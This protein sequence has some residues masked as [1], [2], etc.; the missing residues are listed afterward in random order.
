[1]IDTSASVIAF[2]LVAA[3]LVALI[4]AIAIAVGY[5]SY[6]VASALG[7]AH[8]WDIGILFGLSTIFGGTGAALAR[9]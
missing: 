4:G 9:K 5:L 2:L 6:L 3:L 8:A 7:A 1:M